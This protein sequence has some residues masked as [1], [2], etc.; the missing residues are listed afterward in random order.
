M[1]TGFHTASCLRR[2][3]PVIFAIGPAVLGCGSPAPRVGGSD[4]PPDDGGD[5]GPTS[6]PPPGPTHLDAA[7]SGGTGART[8]AADAPTV[9]AGAADTAAMETGTSDSA[10]PDGA[11]G[12]PSRCPGAGLLICENFESGKIDPTIWRIDGSPEIVADKAA[13]GT[14]SLHMHITPS[15]LG[16]RLRTTGIFPI[17]NN[18]VYVRAF[19]Y[20]SGA[21][22][23]SNRHT[24][25]S[26][27]INSR[28]RYQL[29]IYQQRLH[30]NY[31]GPEADAGPVSRSP[32]PGKDRWLCIE[33]MFDGSATSQVRVWVDGTEDTSLHLTGRTMGPF[34][35][36]AVGA[37][38]YGVD[39]AT[40]DI[41]MDE[42]AVSTS[43]IGCQI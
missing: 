15:A 21:Q 9:R 41:W 13:R 24:T 19:M 18:T 36:L 40:Y 14:H 33:W 6:V 16:S 23:A 42:V 30:T 11:A 31:N 27:G 4:P 29:G 1:A 26:E 43:R 28:Q 3:L 20:Y 10:A 35:T 12:G 25:L 38:Q 34:S 37:Q 5:P 22:L 39:G 32:F 2:A 8:E 7:V 17:T